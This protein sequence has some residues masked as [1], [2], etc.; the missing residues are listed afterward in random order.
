M[1]VRQLHGLFDRVPLELNAVGMGHDRDESAAVDGAEAAGPWRRSDTQA[2]HTGASG[3]N[4]RSSCAAGDGDDLVACDA[5]EQAPTTPQGVRGEAETAAG[6]WALAQ[7]EDMQ[8]AC[9]GAGGFYRR[10][11]DAQNSSRRVLTAIYY[12]NSAWPVSGG[13]HLRIH[14]PHGAARDITP[15]ADRM[16]LFNSH[17]EHEVLPVALGAEG[18][19]ASP[20]LSRCAATQWFQDIAP[21]YLSSGLSTS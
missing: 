20:Q 14:L 6:R 11:S 19:A 18:E 8:L 21:P 15:R 7:V 13:G 16:V 10:H 9:Y 5:A 12:V 4:G 2:S 3:A 1:Q 17:I